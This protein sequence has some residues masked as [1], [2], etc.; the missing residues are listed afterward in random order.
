[1]K[2]LAIKIIIHNMMGIIKKYLLQQ[3]VIR[4]SEIGILGG[5]F[6]SSVINTTLIYIKISKDIV[7]IIAVICLLN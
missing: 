2:Q 6:G 3:K 5:L 1:M 4:A 7:I